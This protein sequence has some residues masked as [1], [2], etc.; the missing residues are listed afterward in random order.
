MSQLFTSGGKSIGVSASASVLPMNIQKLI[1][2]RIDSLDLLAARGTL[3]SL[4]QYH[5]SKSPIL[6]HSA[7]FI[8]QFSHPY[9]TTGKT[10]A[11]TIWNFADKVIFLILNIL[12]RFVT[13]FLPRSKRLLISG[14]PSPSA[15]M[16]ESKKIKSITISIFS[17]SVCQK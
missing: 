5:S 16:L 15:V 4:L 13:A 1:S 9:M 8:V 6:W 2:F 12:S 10:R 11:F 7:F 3:N 17:P 14:L